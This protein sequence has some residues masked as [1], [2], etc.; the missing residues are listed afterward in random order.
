MEAHQRGTETGATRRRHL[1][2]AGIFLAPW[3]LGSVME[4]TPERA[5]LFGLEG[6]ACPSRA[7]GITA[8]CPGCGLTRGCVL[9]L[10]GDLGAA[11]GV[12]AAS[13]L[14]LL[15]SAAGSALHLHIAWR[16]RMGPW[17]RWFGN[18]GRAALASGLLVAWAVR[19]TA[20][21]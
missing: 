18:G 1:L 13:A 19:W 7:L 6:P 21:V 12:N 2:I 11:W 10:H 15:L 5:T 20:G 9:G 8:G 4:A 14:V 16:G 3:T 17:H